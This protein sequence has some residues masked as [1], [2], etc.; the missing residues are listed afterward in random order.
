MLN[1]HILEPRAIS[2]REAILCRKNFNY[3]RVKCFGSGN[4]NSSSFP[5]TA[6]HW[7][8]LSG[9]HLQITW[10]YLSA[11]FF[12][13][14]PGLVTQSRRPG[15]KKS[16]RKC[17]GPIVR[18]G[19]RRAAVIKDNLRAQAKL[20]LVFKLRLACF[21]SPVEVREYRWQQIEFREILC[22]TRLPLTALR[23]Q[24]ERWSGPRELFY[25]SLSCRFRFPTLF[26]AFPF[27]WSVI[28]FCYEDRNGNSEKLLRNQIWVEVERKLWLNPCQCRI[29]FGILPS[30][31]KGGGKGGCPAERE[32][33]ADLLISPHKFDIFG[34]ERRRWTFL[35]RRHC[36]P[37]PFPLHPLT[38]TL[39]PINV[40]RNLG[41][42]IKLASLINTNEQRRK[43][44]SVTVR[45]SQ[46]MFIYSDS[47]HAMAFRD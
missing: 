19:A 14:I 42:A 8:Q 16:A 35:W 9:T 26:P 12:S 23:A 30:M 2:C 29:W 32:P 5:P 13:E 7:D 40:L 18:R 31:K 46:F 17:F 47:M 22:A 28:K 1:K 10:D 6:N 45:R 43:Q 4:W 15:G 25:V 36:H 33:F 34:K 37:K 44:I 11:N 38:E 3:L 27:W 39:N 20:P 41:K 24:K 21:P